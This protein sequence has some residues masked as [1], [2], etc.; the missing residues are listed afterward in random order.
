MKHTNIIFII[1]LLT[2]LFFS[3]CSTYN[4]PKPKEK[5]S[6]NEEEI[7]IKAKKIKEAKK[8]V[9]IEKELLALQTIEVKKYIIGSGDYIH[10]YVY[11]ESDL[12]VQNGLV[13]PDGTYT[14]PLVGDIKISGLT[15]NQAMD[16]ISQRLKKFM[17]EPIVTLIPVKFGSQNY[18]ILG[19]V[20]KSGIY[21]V[22]EGTKV[23]DS[24]ADAGGLSTGEFKG[25]TVELADLE[26]AYIRR[27]G[28]ILPVNFVELVRK[29]NSLHNIPLKNKDYIYIPS[30]LNTEVY[31]LGEAK[32]TGYY[33]YK[34]N[35]TLSQLMSYGEGFNENANIKEI[36]II[37]GG[38]DDPSV[39]IAD[40]EA[41]LEGKSL[42]FR[43]KPYD[44]VFI[45]KTTLGDWNSILSMV[46]PTLNLIPS[47]YNFGQ[48][49]VDLNNLTKDKLNW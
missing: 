48:S 33:G 16:T 20:M 46:T 37:R 49:A 11:G 24:I 23:L 6:L 14:V 29:G 22:S 43:L 21:P 12:T 10:F 4:S 40:F 19:K 9:Q 17:I 28:K 25:T 27:D 39:Y 3:G 45:P 7:D 41:I 1:S 15:I 35:M 30:A 2:T 34:E 44:I 47:I 5:I 31:L 18:T 8:K 32:T 42:D 13:K 26:H 36:A 38:L